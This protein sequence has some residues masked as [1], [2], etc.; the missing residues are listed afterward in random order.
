MS[1]NLLPAQSAALPTIAIKYIAGFP[2]GLR[3]DM[4]TAQWKRDADPITKKGETVR[5]KPIA[6]RIFHA[7]LFNYVAKK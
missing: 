5:L 6:I 2:Y 7:Q 3:V 1:K 4:K